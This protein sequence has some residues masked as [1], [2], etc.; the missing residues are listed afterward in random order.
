MNGFIPSSRKHDCPICGDTSG[1]CRASA[2]DTNYF[3][4]F[5]HSGARKFEIINGHKA[6]GLTKDGLWMQFVVE[7]GQPQAN[8]EERQK[9]RVAREAKINKLHRSGLNADQRHATHTKL[10][11]QLSLNEADRTDLERRGASAELIEMCRSIKPGQELKSAINPKTPGVGFGGRKLLTRTAGYLIPAF[12]PEGRILGFQIRNRAGDKPRYPWLSV[13]DRAPVNLTSGEMPITVVR[14]GDDRSTLYLM[15]GIL[16]PLIASE[17]HGINVLGAS[18]GLFASSPK[19][20]RQ[21]ISALLPETIALCPDAGAIRNHHVMRHYTELHDELVT[22]GRELKVLWWNQRTK[23]DGDI[24]EITAEQFRNAELITWAQFKAKDISQ[25]IA[26]R[27]TAKP[28]QKPQKVVGLLKKLNEKEQRRKDWLDKMQQVSGAKEATREAINAELTAKQ[29]LPAN[30]EEGQYPA[31]K[32][33]PPN[34]RRLYLLDGQKCTRKTSKAIKSLVDAARLA[35]LSCLVIVP[36]R[37]LSRDASKV[38]GTACHLD[39]NA[40]AA[41]YL[42][43]CPESLYKFAGQHW[44]VVVFDEVNEDIK[45][46]FD[47]SLGVNPELCQ[48]VTRR[49]LENASTIAIANDGMYRVSVQAIQRLAKITPQEVITVQRKRPPSDVTMHLYM[50]CLGGSDEGEENAASFGSDTYYGWLGKLAEAIE[51]GPVAIPCGSQAKARDIDRVLRSHFKGQF[52]GQ[53]L[54][55]PVTPTRVKSEFAAEPDAWLARVKP[56]WLIWTPCFNSGVSIESD[57]FHSQFECISNFESSAAASQRGERVRAVLLGGIKERHVYVSNRGLPA[58]P[59]PAIFTP[60][61]WEELGKAAIEGRTTPIDRAMARSIGADEYLKRHRDEL[62]SELANKSELFDY[63]A[64][65]ARELFFKVESLKAEWLSNGWTLKNADI[66]NVDIEFWRKAVQTARQ[67]IIESK[68]RALAKAKAVAGEGQDLSPYAAVRARKHHL[69]EQLGDQYDRLQDSEWLEAWAIAPDNSGGI[70]NQRIFK[71]IE[72]SAKEPELWAAIRRLD[73]MRSIA[74]GIEIENIP[75]LPIPAKEIATAQLLIE[76][77]GIVGVITGE[78]EV[79]NK[80]SQFVKDAKA[81]LLKHSQRL[82]ALSKHSQRILGYQFK[83]TTPLIKCINKALAMAGVQTTCE[84]RIKRVWNYRV[85]TAPD[86]ERKI[87]QK[88]S[89]GKDATFADK[90]DLLRMQTIG[91]LRDCIGVRLKQVV[92]EIA[93]KWQALAEEIA[94]TAQTSA[95]ALVPESCEGIAP[96]KIIVP[97]FN[98]DLEGFIRAIELCDKFPDVIAVAA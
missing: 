27:S 81:Y 37:L 9:A 11:A 80:T 55:G 38:L 33:A 8:Y 2:N 59:D 32:L 65:E 3:Q 72:M 67:S 58:Y 52:K 45:R 93:P 6:I 62:L 77:P 21:C 14:G 18:G 86:L 44:D 41:R 85:S 46:T 54:D 23:A 22:L 36:S 16:K 78:I 34:E 12:D 49:I 17:K 28:A 90:R 63:W 61:Y 51:K 96:T 7:A 10:L 92:G 91:E 25:P 24:D 29:L 84:G 69:G 56:R 94:A 71:L 5:T 48:R 60:N 30:H 13:G 42:T 95:P 47:G 35:G 64:I 40:E 73:T 66:E 1:N 97:N 4:C 31:L 19:Q 83:E 82:A 43:T 89:K 20:L 88:A 15:E 39:R 75:T 50:D 26:Q 53:V 57:Y 79:W 74:S 76:C 70:K 68:S 87:E 98:H